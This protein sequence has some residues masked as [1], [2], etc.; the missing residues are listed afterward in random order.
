[1]GVR[2]AQGIAGFA[3]LTTCGSVWSCPVCNAKIMARRALEIGAAVESWTTSGGAV[4]FLTLT[5]R[6]DRGQTLREVWDGVAKAWKRVIQGRPWLR[7]RDELGIAGIIRVIEVTHGRNGWHVHVHALV[8]TETVQGDEILR[9]FFP[10]WRD[11]AV[12]AG[13]VA[14]LMRGQDVRVVQAAT[15]EALAAYLAK[16]QLGAVGVELTATQGK[17]ARSALS[18]RTTWDIL[19]DARDGL[20]DEV[21]LWQAWEINSKGRRQISWSRGLRDLLGL[22]L[23]EDDEVIAAEELGTSDDTIAVVTLQGWYDLG[24]LRLLAQCLQ[25]AETGG[26]FG[27]KAFLQEHEIAHEL[28]VNPRGEFTTSGIGAMR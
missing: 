11:G 25:A 16:S 28:V 26:Q 20:A 12:K 22:G 5:V 13:L 7:D 6:H 8:L 4:Q 2:L 24:R 17:K 27:L 14:P 10:R 21:D 23:D 1:V 19:E 3:G 15:D 18:T 9:R